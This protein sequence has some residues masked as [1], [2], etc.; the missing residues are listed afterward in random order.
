MPIDY[1]ASLPGSSRPVDTDQPQNTT[2]LTAGY[3]IPAVSAKRAERV[4]K[5]NAPNLLKPQ[6]RSKFLKM[7]T[8]FRTLKYSSDQPQDGTSDQPYI[9]TELSRA[10]EGKNTPTYSDNTGITGIQLFSAI[11]RDRITK[12]LNTNTKGK[13]FK[14][15]Q[16]QLAF[17]NPKTEVGLNYAYV[18]TIAP[19][20]LDRLIPNSG[21]AGG[22]EFTRVYNDN[23]N[24][25]QQ[26]GVQGSGIHF[27]APGAQPVIPFQSK[28]EY[29][30][31][32]KDKETNRLV[33]LFNNKIV[34]NSFKN[35]ITTPNLEDM[36]KTGIAR[37]QNKIF[38]YL[39]GPGASDSN[40]LTVIGRYTYTTDWKSFSA[41]S[42]KNQYNPSTDKLVNLLARNVPYTGSIDPGSGQQLEE[43]AVSLKRG[44]TPGTVITKLDTPFPF[45]PSNDKHSLSHKAY[46]TSS[47]ALDNADLP[48]INRSR[49]MRY[50]DIISAKKE[51]ERQATIK[52]DFRIEAGDVT[53]TLYYDSTGGMIAKNLVG[54]PGNIGINRVSYD[55][56][57]KSSTE[58]PANALGVDEI[59][60]TDVG[61]GGEDKDFIKCVITAIETQQTSANR[62][63]PMVFR[64]FVTNFTDNINA[65]Y[66]THQY[67]GR[68]ENFY[69]YKNAERKVS[70]Q[71]A[72]AAQSR[73]EMQPLYRKLNYLVS[74]LYP[75]YSGFI[76]N[77]GNGFMRAPLVKMTIGD[78][79]F[80]QPGFLTSISITIPNDAP[81]EIVYDKLDK[82]KD[83]YQ[84][85]HHLNMNIAFTP[86]HN[87]VA[88]RSHQSDAGGLEYSITPFITPNSPTNLFGIAK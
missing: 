85:P 11:D 30:V 20:V 5:A 58:Y 2:E 8:N 32:N 14:D 16:R 29:V 53:S 35:L 57:G 22:L 77:K 26:I 1:L 71:L 34:D 81:W 87:F 82:D 28:Y 50:V 76:N 49:V 47:F 51:Y 23:I 38:E 4:E 10:F 37:G 60:A 88:K 66:D 12:F 86:I 72:I 54:D 9:K 15:K 42:D 43:V 55:K 39:G 68:G 13:L 78:Y 45:D 3:E 64:A 33:L 63:V 40:S 61:S 6:E 75:G 21:K 41:Y 19:G 79:L 44:A 27:D 31:K 25:L 56:V 65:N 18:N 7:T 24:L 73:A 46:V 52:P 69:T 84:L 83:M 70:F 80:D 36:N 59:N 74:Q 67:V 48:D 62:V 17:F